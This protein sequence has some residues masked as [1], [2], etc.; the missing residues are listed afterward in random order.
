MF[1]YRA[2][3]INCVI[4]ICKDEFIVSADNNEIRYIRFT[5]TYINNTPMTLSYWP[6]ASLRIVPTV[7]LTS[8]VFNSLFFGLCVKLL[9][10]LLY[11]NTGN[12][13]EI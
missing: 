11:S 8:I 13:T 6:A 5:A 7:L 3:N 9:P 1:F 12:E 2:K 10:E 4:Y